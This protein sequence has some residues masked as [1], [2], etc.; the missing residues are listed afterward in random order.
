LLAGGGTRG[1]A[2]LAGPP[3]AARLH[4]HRRPGRPGE[5]AAGNRRP[6]DPLLSLVPR[7]ARPRPVARERPSH[8]RRARQRE[9]PGGPPRPCRSSPDRDR[10]DG[11][12]PAPAARHGAAL[13]GARRPSRAP[14]RRGAEAHAVSLPARHLGVHA[15][16]PH[17]LPPARAAARP[18]PVRPLPEVPRRRQSAPARPRHGGMAPPRHPPVRLASGGA[19]GSRRAAAGR[20]RFTDSSLLRPPGPGRRADQPPLAARRDQ[21]RRR[22]GRGTALVEPLAAAPHAGPR[23][24]LVAPAAATDPDGILKVAGRTPTRLLLVGA[25]HAHLEILRRLILQ[26]LPDV[27]LTVVSLGNLHHYSGMVPGF[28]QG[29]Y[30]EDEIAVRVPDLVARGRGQFLAGR[31]VALRPKS[32]VVHVQTGPEETVEVPW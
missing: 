15:P 31:A 2:G 30:R 32:Q 6:P 5:P 7:R 24:P 12:R 22:A 28:L 27:A 29:T 23:H 17:S 18:R 11:D 25:G 14:R 19:Q 26:P 21:R 4:L 10:R 20:R 16:G 13:P 8:G 9:H 3:G 1:A